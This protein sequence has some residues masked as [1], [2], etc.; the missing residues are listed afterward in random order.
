[1]NK[2]NLKAENLGKTFDNREWIYK[3]INL[4]LSNNSAVAIKGRN[5]S[6]K[7]TLLKTLA[8][9]RQKG[10]NIMF[11]MNLVA[12]G[13]GNLNVGDEITIKV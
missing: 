8:A 3:K 9:F 10:S 6:G 4:E 2:F 1:M 13:M 12:E 7:S 11:G 5:G